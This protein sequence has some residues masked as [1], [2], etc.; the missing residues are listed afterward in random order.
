MKSLDRMLSVWPEAS[1]DIYEKSW[2]EFCEFLDPETVCS[3]L[4]EFHLTK[5]VP[6]LSNEQVADLKQCVKADT[7]SDHL[8]FDKA[9][10]C[11][12]LEAVEEWGKSLR[13]AWIVACLQLG[14]ADEAEDLALTAGKKPREE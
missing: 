8:P 12:A 6:Y 5:I 2:V 9:V 11:M 13:C 7:T 4:V 10:Y 1:E 14:L 3:Q